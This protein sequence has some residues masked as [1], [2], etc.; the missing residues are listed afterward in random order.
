M[1]QGPVQMAL[2]NKRCLIYKPVP[3]PT[4][5]KLPVSR[6]GSHTEHSGR[7]RSMDVLQNLASTGLVV[8][9]LCVPEGFYEPGLVVRAAR[10]QP[11]PSPGGISLSFFQ[12]IH[13]DQRG[14]AKG[15]IRRS[16]GTRQGLVLC[17]L[18]TELLQTQHRRAL[19]GT[20]GSITAPQAS[21][22]YGKGHQN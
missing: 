10:E 1:L 2:L 3:D 15:E 20:G 16:Q 7:D 11:A 14:K 22:N 18:K 21:I 5:T 12:P 8:E 9:A 4:R 13:C 19:G 17:L 6:S